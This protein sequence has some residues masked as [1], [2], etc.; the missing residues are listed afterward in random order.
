MNLRELIN[1]RGSVDEG[2]K[3]A[4]KVEHKRLFLEHRG[5]IRLL[6]WLL[7]IA[8]CANMGAVVL[9]NALVVRETPPDELQLIEANPVQAEM[10]D[11]QGAPEEVYMPILMAFFRQAVMWTFIVLGYLWQ[12]NAFYTETGVYL[13]TFCALWLFFITVPDFFNNF[14]YWVAL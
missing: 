1:L 10:N 12:R 13:L 7:I 11:Y 2:I 9:T 8:F 6:D 4:R 5:F 3:K 14:G